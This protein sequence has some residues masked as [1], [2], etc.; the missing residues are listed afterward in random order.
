[1]KHIE[2]LK[3]E[4][5][6]S[7]ATSTERNLPKPYKRKRFYTPHDVAEHSASN[8]CWV[9]FFHDVFDLT[10]LVQNNFNCISF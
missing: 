10:P 7:S 5:S 9:T 3:V 2:P 1:M 8:D 6:K 4:F